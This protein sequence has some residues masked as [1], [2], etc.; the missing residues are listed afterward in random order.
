MR[1]ARRAPPWAVVVGQGRPRRH[2]LR[3]RAPWLVCCVAAASIVALGG[4]GSATPV[5]ADPARHGDTH[6]SRNA[7]DWAGVYEGVLPCADCPGI[8]T[9]LTLQ[10]DGRFEL[11]M[12][13]IERR[14]EPFVSS[15]RFSWN[16]DGNT[17]TLDD[18]AMYRVQEGSVLQLDRDGTPPRPDSLNR[19]LIKIR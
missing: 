12:R 17:I 16:A 8:R 3:T 15:G 11:S 19:T 7:L 9:R 6:N 1:T 10:Q 13:Y 5:A 14:V 18:G 4:C 2:A